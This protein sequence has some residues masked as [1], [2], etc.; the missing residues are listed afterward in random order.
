MSV[1]YE[2]FVSSSGLKIDFDDSFTLSS[3]IMGATDVF[4]SFHDARKPTGKMALS[5][6]NIVFAT[7]TS[8]KKHQNE[9]HT[10]CFWGI[11]FGTDLGI[12]M[13]PKMDPN[14]GQKLNN[15][16]ASI[17]MKFFC[18][19]KKYSFLMQKPYFGDP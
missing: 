8:S 7:E 12:E 17:S 18:C 15:I 4:K 14:L 5:H 13:A 10:I 19:C 6:T 2:E 11:S 1:F 9:P 16:H 3:S